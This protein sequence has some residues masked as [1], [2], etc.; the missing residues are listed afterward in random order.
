MLRGSPYW[1]IVVGSLLLLAS[2]FGAVERFERAGM[3]SGA[4]EA[5]VTGRR[6]RAYG[7]AASAPVK[8]SG[9]IVLAPVGLALAAFGVWGVQRQGRLLRDGIPVVGYI[10]DIE[11]ERNKLPCLV[12]RFEDE[13][14]RRHEGYYQ[15][16]LGQLLDDYR[17]GQEVTV[18]YDARNPRIHL[19]DIDEV[20]RAEA[21]LR[22][23][24]S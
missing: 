4:P 16:G 1:A 13:E 23:L 20:R 18:V 10:A 24:E 3:D 5:P 6:L 9:L 22:R 19:L 21:R 2:A 15:T 14:G 11:Q 12:Y 7:S 8:R 17:M